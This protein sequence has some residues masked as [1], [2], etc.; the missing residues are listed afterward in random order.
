MS[1]A[2]RFT[3]SS[4]VRLSPQY[5]DDRRGNA[6]YHPR[7]GGSRSGIIAMVAAWWHHAHFQLRLPGRSQ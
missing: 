1:E 3:L 2:A 7:P 4:S 6:L 5:L